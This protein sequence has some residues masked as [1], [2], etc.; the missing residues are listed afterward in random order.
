MGGVT[1]PGLAVAEF[2][3]DIP[4]AGGKNIRSR[5]TRPGQQDRDLFAEDTGVFVEQQN[6]V[7]KQGG[8]IRYNAKRC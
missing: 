4:A 1:G 8:R 3:P 5:G 2:P 6:P 7:G